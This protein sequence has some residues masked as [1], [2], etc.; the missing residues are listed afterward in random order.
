M[1][2][3]GFAEK[4]RRPCL[5]V[6]TFLTISSRN[7]VLTELQPYHISHDR[8]KKKKKNYSVMMCIPDVVRVI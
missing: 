6:E 2:K 8:G 1:L 3:H 5:S 4:E 7:G